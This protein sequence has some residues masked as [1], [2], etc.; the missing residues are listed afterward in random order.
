MNLFDLTYFMGYEISRQ[1]GIF[2]VSHCFKNNSNASMNTILIVN[3]IQYENM[4]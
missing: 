1:R 3:Y 4:C 2:F